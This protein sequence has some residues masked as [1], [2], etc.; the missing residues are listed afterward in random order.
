M[1]RKAAVLRLSEKFI[2]SFINR[3][4]FVCFLLCFILVRLKETKLIRKI[5][6]IEC[7]AELSFQTAPIF[8]CFLFT[9]F[10]IYK[11]SIYIIFQQAI[12]I[13]FYGYAIVQQRPLTPEVAFVSL[14]LFNM[15]RVAIYQLPSCLIS[16]SQMLVSGRRILGLLV[17]EEYG[18]S[19]IINST[20]ELRQNGTTALS[21]DFQRQPNKGILFRSIFRLFTI[22]CLVIHLENCSFTWGEINSSTSTDVQKHLSSISL[23]VNKGSSTNIH[24][25]NIDIQNLKVN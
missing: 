8:V 17:E 13:S 16:T 10:I 1:R 20:D 9:H 3:T 4:M 11:H 2:V 22:F 24:N 12:L 14:L 15:L 23:S 6:F 5:F 19:H 18:T 7:G 21:I 25:G